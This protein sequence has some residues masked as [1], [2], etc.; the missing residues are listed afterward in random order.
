M[1]IADVGAFDPSVSL[2]ANVG[3]RRNSAAGPASGKVSNRTVSGRS[4]ARRIRCR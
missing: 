2:P 4:A 1:R 3:L